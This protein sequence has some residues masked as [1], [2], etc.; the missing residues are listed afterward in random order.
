MRASRW[1]FKAK[2][3]TLSAYARLFE[4][5][6]NCE[7]AETSRK[8][9][10]IDT[11]GREVSQAGRATPLSARRSPAW[12]R[13]LL[14]PPVAADSRAADS[15]PRDNDITMIALLDRSWP[16]LPGCLDGGAHLVSDLRRLPCV[17]QQLHHSGADAHVRVH[18]VEGCR[19]TVRMRMRT[20]AFC[21]R[22]RHSVLAALPRVQPAP[23]MRYPAAS[24]SIKPTS[25]GG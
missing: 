7:I 21:C 6:D 22:R 8:S 23:R 1:A 4:F 25:H 11:R 12:R 15:R 10:F 2:T 9:I 17:Q 20:A 14:A 16:G 19:E 13:S 18:G 3:L 24:R 5:G